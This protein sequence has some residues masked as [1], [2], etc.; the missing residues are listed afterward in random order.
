MAGVDPTLQDNIE[1]L[2]Y[3][4]LCVPNDSAIIQL[5]SV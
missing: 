2:N 1:I 5:E 4:H 3:P